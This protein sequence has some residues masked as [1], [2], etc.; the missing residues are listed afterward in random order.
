[1]DLFVLLPVGWVDVEVEPVLDGLALRHARECQRRW[2]W[3]K[4]VLAFGHR[5]GANCDNSVVFVL[6]LVVEYRAPEP[7]ET[8]GIGTVDRKLGELAGHVSSPVFITTT[9][10]LIEPRTES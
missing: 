10:R 7:S 3:A 5:R 8:G 9:G 4:A 2:H 6:H 1:M